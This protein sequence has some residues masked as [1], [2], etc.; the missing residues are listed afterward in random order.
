[1]NEKVKLCLCLNNLEPHNEDALGMEVLDRGELSAS[2]TGCFTP[3]ETGI[4]FIGVSVDLQ[5]VWTPWSRQKSVVSASTRT[6]TVQPLVI[7][8]ELL[9]GSQ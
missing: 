8:A 5:L 1:M 9:L 4:H 3:R 2:R 7:S 6:P